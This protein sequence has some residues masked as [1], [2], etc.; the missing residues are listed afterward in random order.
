MY[1]VPDLFNDTLDGPVRHCLITN[2]D[3]QN[4]EFGYEKGNEI[5]KELRVL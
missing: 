2:L 4:G 3:A 1:L 5:K